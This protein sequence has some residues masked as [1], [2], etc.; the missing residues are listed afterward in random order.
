MRLK[1]LLIDFFSNKSD[2]LLV[3][4]YGSFAAGRETDKSDV[5]I[6]SHLLAESE[7]KP[8]KTMGEF[9]QFMKTVNSL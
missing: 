8:P 2:I 4:L 5:D 6:A 1:E 7:Q 3:I 9:K